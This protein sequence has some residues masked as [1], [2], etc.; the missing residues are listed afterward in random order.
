MSE[1]EHPVSQS[2]HFFLG[3]ENYV[4]GFLY[5]FFMAHILQIK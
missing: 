2:E 5:D 1:N 4:A 3:L